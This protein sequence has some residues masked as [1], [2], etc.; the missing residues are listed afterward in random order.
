MDFSKL[1]SKNVYAS[2]SKIKDKMNSDLNIVLSSHRSRAGAVT[3]RGKTGEAHR[4]L[5]LP[6]SS[7]RGR[8]HIG[9]DDAVYGSRSNLIAAARSAGGSLALLG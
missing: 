2:P 4:N 8:G 3:H 9:R 1:L 7:G 5:P 6:D